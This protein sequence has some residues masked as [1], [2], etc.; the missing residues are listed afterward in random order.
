MQ[1]KSPGTVCRGFF[2]ELRGLAELAHFRLWFF[3]FGA[4]GRK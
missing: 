2:A 4:R 3:Y 1:Q